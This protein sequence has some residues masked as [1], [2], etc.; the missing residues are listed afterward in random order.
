MKNRINNITTQLIIEA[1]DS[2]FPGAGE[3]GN[4]LSLFDDLLVEQHITISPFYKKVKNNENEEKEN[5]R[6][7][8]D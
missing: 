8:A 2:M 3:K 4:R 5:N 6:T 1:A 7:R